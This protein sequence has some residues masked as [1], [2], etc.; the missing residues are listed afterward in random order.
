ME[1][2][3]VFFDENGL[4]STSANY[5]ANK[6]KEYIRVLEE[7]INNVSFVSK[8]V[9]SII[10]NKETG[11]LNPG[12]LIS[13]GYDENKA[14]DIVIQIRKVCEI[15]SLIAWLREAIKAK[16]QMSGNVARKV[17]VEWLKDNGYE[18]KISP[19][20][21][22]CLNETTYFESLPIKERNAYYEYETKA[23]V[24]GK[25]IHEETAPISKARKELAKRISN[26]VDIVGEGQDSLIY[27]YSPTLTIT[28]VNS[29]FFGL[30]EE[31]REAQA[32]LN[33]MK[34]KMETAINESKTEVMNTYDKELKAYNAYIN[35]KSHEFNEWK[36]KTQ[37]EI[38]KL[39]I[40]IP[41]SL[42]DTYE[43]INNLH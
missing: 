13:L 19:S 4:T 35:E 10:D 22:T 27:T 16:E 3:A 32:Q 5:I 37:I 8:S 11:V 26:P 6:A 30:Q 24:I 21:G 39:K 33:A 40:V 18:V 14:A 17:F 15:K 41:N 1:N 28:H 2:K 42:K 31:Y 7:E 43:F 36:R 34:Y 20:V 12:T 38:G 25:L 29:I 23:A 9:K